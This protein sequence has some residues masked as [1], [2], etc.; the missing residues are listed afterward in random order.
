[1]ITVG[2]R[3]A[4]LVRE[5]DAPARGCR[6]SSAAAATP[7]GSVASASFPIRSSSRSAMTKRYAA[8][9]TQKPVGTGSRAELMIPRLSALP[10]TALIMVESMS[11]KSTS[12][13]M[14][15]R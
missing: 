15:R 14:N 13:V 9:V 12:N 7:P 1:M 5:L 10:P 4:E 11:E 3:G 8:V 2:D 6:A